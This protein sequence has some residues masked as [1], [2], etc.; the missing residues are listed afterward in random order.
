MYGTV[1]KYGETTGTNG[2]PR[3]PCTRVENAATRFFSRFGR[4]IVI[5]K[6]NVE[7]SSPFARF[8]AS[9]EAVNPALRAGAPSLRSGGW[10][11]GR[12]CGA[13]RVPLPAF[14]GNA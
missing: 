12:P 4:G 6:L 3:L 9:L 10:A 2:T 8:L 14:A 7:G 5:P 13:L 1:R 11:C